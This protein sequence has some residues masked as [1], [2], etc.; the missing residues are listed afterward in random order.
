MEDLPIPWDASDLSF[1]TL[2]SEQALFSVGDSHYQ[3]AIE[4]TDITQLYGDNPV[5]SD[6]VLD[7][8]PDVDWQALLGTS[9]RQDGFDFDLDNVREPD[10]GGLNALLVCMRG[11]LCYRSLANS[12]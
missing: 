8:Q 4:N 12:V 7:P 11:N 2:P 5:V 6:L 1:F 10:D 9:A 3:A